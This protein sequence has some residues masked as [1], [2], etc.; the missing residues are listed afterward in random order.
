MLFIKTFLIND[1]RHRKRNE[2]VTAMKKPKPTGM[3]QTSYAPSTETLLKA[4]SSQWSVRGVAEKL[5]L[6]SERKAPEKK[7]SL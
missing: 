2:R 5:S 4:V 1:R 7:R 3:K 6:G